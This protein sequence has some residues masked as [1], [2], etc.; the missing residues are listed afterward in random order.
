[1]KESKLKSRLVANN[2]NSHLRD[3]GVRN[4][5]WIHQLILNDMQIEYLMTC[6]CSHIRQQV[7]RG[8]VDRAGSAS[9]LSQRKANDARNAKQRIMEQEGSR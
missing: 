8:R 1:M 9:I 3:V 5:T 4:Q 2:N 6:M 7:S